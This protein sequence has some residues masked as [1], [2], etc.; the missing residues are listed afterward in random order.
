LKA[1]S[2][3]LAPLQGQ[4][5]ALSAGAGPVGV[6]L[7]GLGPIGLTA[8]I[9]LGAVE[10]AFSAASTM[11]HE[12]ALKARELRD[13]ADNTGLTI[14]ELKAL[15]KVAVSV[16][17]SAE[18]T[19][20][21]IERMTVSLEEMR[22][23][24][25]KGFDTLFKYNSGLAI[26]IASTRS[27]ADAI[28]ILSKAYENLDVVQRNAL[29]RAVFGRGGID[30]SRVLGADAEGG[31][32]AGVTKAAADAGRS[33]DENMIR[34]V[35]QLDIEIEESSKRMKNNFVKAFG[36]D[37]LR[38][39]KT[40]LDYLTDI[41]AKM[42]KISEIKPTSGW[43]GLFTGM[44]SI[45]PGFMARPD[46]H[47]A[48]GSDTGPLSPL[49][50]S[51]VRGAVGSSGTFDI[52]RP[53]A[54]T[55]LTAQASLNIMEKWMSVL[56]PAATQSELLAQEQLKLNAAME[57]GGV[58]TTVAARAIDQFKFSQSQANEAAKESLGVSSQQEIASSRLAALANQEARGLKLTSD[59]RA[60]A[61]NIIQREARATAEA[62]QVRASALPGLTQMGI[63]FGRLD[64][65]VDAFAV[66]SMNNMVTSLA[67]FT[68]G[69]KTGA[70]A[71]QNFA[72]TVVRGLEEMIIKMLIIAPLAKSIT[73]AVSPFL[74]GAGGGGGGSSTAF[75][76]HSGGIVGIDGTP[77]YV[78]PAYFD[79]APRLHGGLM[80]DEFPAI[81]QRGETVIPRGGGGGVVNNFQVIAPPGSS[82][83]REQKQNGT[84]GV[85]IVAIIDVAQAK[86]MATPGSA[87]NRIMRSGFGIAP[88]LTRR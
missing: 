6:F 38:A 23:G 7:A 59:Q 76:M 37:V 53:P 41:L 35:A 82:V 12:F 20:S 46:L 67:D 9:G 69:A 48:P 27:T 21:S 86:N 39:E 51:G 54:A 16:G 40:F 36:E 24:S 31:G 74:G 17:V 13:M 79:F 87:T 80:S 32:L 1:F 55:G 11:A 14:N 88:G 78:H 43:Q 57:K 56:G 10:K 15:E 4:L 34:R 65:Q 83:S 77:R 3:A 45:V 8:A 2:A 25:G 58:S 63:E 85:D 26:Q 84:G 52:P 47:G 68:T 62:A 66:T 64:K 18:K 29:S 61:V 28:T 19:G 72:N 73:G 33:I 81:L 49:T 60:L 70:E 71:F 30:M 44:E 5:I 42:G 22:Q 50:L 75:G